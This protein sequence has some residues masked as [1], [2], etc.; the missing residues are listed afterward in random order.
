MTK[1]KSV[2]VP[3][4]P[5]QEIIK[6]NKNSFN[7]Q[8]LK[9]NLDRVNMWIG[10]CDQKTS[11]VL[12]ALCVGLTIL[13]TSDF[14]QYVR[15]KLIVPLKTYVCDQMLL[16]DWYRIAI[17]ITLVYVCIGFIVIFYHLIFSLRAKTNIKQFAQPGIE[18]SSMFHYETVAGKTYKE[19]CESEV[20]ILNDLR[21]QVY[22][23]SIICT[24]KF[25]HYNKAIKA[26]CCTLP[27]AILLAI[28][29]IFS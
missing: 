26:L 9:E 6:A 12:A 5:G 7:E 14:V 20:H 21:S 18:R 19:Y 24:A 1:S 4:T 29:I 2:H 23:N 27:G 13:F 22:I 11:I 15:K 28:L 10:N 8:D 3:Q 16:S 25:K 17:A